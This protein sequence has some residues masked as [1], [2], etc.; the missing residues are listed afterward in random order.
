[1]IKSL[2]EIDHQLSQKLFI[3]EDAVSLRKLASFFAH[4]GD[5]WFLEAGLLLTW[6]FSEGITHTYAALFAGA[7]I[8]QATLVILI[9][10]NIKRK[11]PEGN[12]GAIYRNT[13]P[14]AFPSGHAA[15]TMMIACM[16]LGLSFP[17]LFWILLFWSILVSLSRVGLGVH[18]LTDIIGGWIIGV[19]LALLMVSA[20]P[21]F[22]RLIPFVF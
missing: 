14:N 17:I 16:A 6:I 5:S 22:Y 18:F 13:D 20:Q 10:F 3:D 11:R 21:F 2:L 15:R 8:I 1:M 19:F 7:I 4:S 9:K 12:W